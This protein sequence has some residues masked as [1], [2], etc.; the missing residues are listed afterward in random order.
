[1]RGSQADSNTQAE[2]VADGLNGDWRE[3]SRE[4][5][6]GEARTIGRRTV[7]HPNTDHRHKQIQKQ[8]QKYKL[9]GYQEV[10]RNQAG[11]LFIET[12]IGC[13]FTASLSASVL[14][15]WNEKDFENY[16]TKQHPNPLIAP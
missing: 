4:E 9:G 5:K 3:V 10:R 16:T 15:G 7:A 11:L 2:M 6:E 12:R 1:M 14:T 13:Q 8:M